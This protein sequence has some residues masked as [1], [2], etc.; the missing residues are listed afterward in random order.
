MKSLIYFLKEYKYELLA[1]SVNAVTLL[2]AYAAWN[3]KTVV[4]T[5][6][7]IFLI[8]LI[9]VIYSRS[10]EKEFYFIPFNKPQN[11]DNWIGKGRF[12]YLQSE[13]SFVITDADP[14]YIFSNCL[15]WSNYKFSFQFKL[16]NECLG[17]VVKAVNLSNYVMLQIVPDGIRP[18]IRING[19]WQAWE[20]KQANLSF[21]K[22]IKKD[23]WYTLELTC[24][25]DFIKIVIFEK[26]KIFFDRQWTVP[27]GQMLFS[28]KKDEN[29]KPTNIPFSIN[30]EYGSAGFRNWGPEK[31]LIK[32]F[33]IEKINK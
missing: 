8:S 23:N 30:L 3:N 10:K 5:S 14:G 18:H 1:H 11:K 7:L 15:N 12:E 16:I 25:K 29:D 19:S 27:S 33:L 31:S 4:F 22:T 20:H 21:S 32:N 24:E 2:V 26:N 9:F 13:N 28:F 6:L 17:V